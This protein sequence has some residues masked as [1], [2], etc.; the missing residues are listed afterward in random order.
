MLK[1]DYFK[2]TPII[3]PKAPA[4][5]PIKIIIIPSNPIEKFELNILEIIYNIN[6]YKT[7]LVIPCKN[8]FKI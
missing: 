3:P 7:P 5:I 4:S 2:F 1:I 8:T 6:I